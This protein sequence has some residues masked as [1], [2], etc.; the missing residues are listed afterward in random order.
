MAPRPARIVKHL[1]VVLALFVPTLVFLGFDPAAAAGGPLVSRGSVRLSSLVSPAGSETIANPEFAQSVEEDH[2]TDGGKPPPRHRRGPDAASAPV[3]PAGP[4]AAVTFAGLNHRDNRLANGGN[5]FSSEPPD[6]ALCVGPSHVLEG[7][8]TVMRVYDKSG[9]PVSPTIS[10]NE[11]FGYPPAIDRAT[12]TFGAFITDPVCHFDPASGRFFLGVLTLDQDPTTGDFTGKNRLDLAVSTTSDPTGVWKRYSM[13]VQNDGTQGTPDHNCDGDPTLPPQVTNPSACIGDY[14]HIGADRY[15]IYIT[16][17]EY[18]FFGDG[19][20]GGAAYT[21]SQIYAISKAQLVSGVPTPTIV[22]FN[23]PKLGKFRSFTVWPAVAPAGKDSTAS[24]G[25][26]FLLSSTL[27]DGSETGNTAASED[28]IGLWSL[29]N[30]RSLDDA[31]PAVRLQN[32]LIKADTYTLPP[33]ATQKDGPTPLKDCLNDRTDR[34]G[35]GLGCWALFLDSEPTQQEVTSPLDSSDTRMQQV[36]YSRGTVFG[37][38]DTGVTPTTRGH[39]QSP[40]AGAL[41]VG[42]KPTFKHGKLK[43]KT[44]RSGY[45]TVANNDVAY[46][47][48]GVTSSGRVVMAA[49]LS[50]RDH[51]PSASYTVVTDPRP[52]V[53]VISEG[54]G[55]QDGFTGYRAF[56]DPPRPRWGDYGAAAMDGSTL[57]VA[58]ESIEQSCTLD[59]YLAAPIGSCGDTRTALAN[60]G[61]RVT[62]LRF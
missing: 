34:F 17:N 36:V 8:N 32:R 46:P 1:V 30:T 12:G 22:N 44:E 62:G 6:Q 58:S 21:G 20:N 18:S 15:G 60:W 2:A 5:Q 31:T 42:V 10:F 13:P 55:P 52:T 45:V 27:G 35:P 26:E 37:A 61:T 23:S 19:S 51:F 39:S 53:R 7:V 38:L 24:G 41:W 28:R 9:A 48:L 50:G 3:A 49:T 59:E 25:T 33:K 57:W 56:G 4:E 47:A 16:T 14:P 11:F 29:T 54:L 43:G 40:R